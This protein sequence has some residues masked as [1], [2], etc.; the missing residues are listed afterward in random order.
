VIA[1]AE[2]KHPQCAADPVRCDHDP[3][4]HGIGEILHGL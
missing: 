1:C 4:R 2:G 3:D